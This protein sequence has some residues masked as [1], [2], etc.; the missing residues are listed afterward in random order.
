MFILYAVVIGLIAG[1]AVGGRLD[2][3]G[4]IEFRWPWLAIG[5]FFVQVLL[6]SAAVSSAVGSAGPPV[7]VAS[8]AAVLVAVVRNVH[9]PGLVVVAVGAASNL[10]AIVSNGG[11]MPASPGA[12]ASL[13]RS[14]DDGYTN[15][16]IVAS[17]AFEPLTD[18]YALPGWVPLANVFSVGDV[19]IAAGV[20]MVLVVGMR[21]GRG[22]SPVRDRPDDGVQEEAAPDVVPAP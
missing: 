6:F 4:R 22:S 12:F 8:T 15:S 11:F 19:L 9:I 17:P 21:S 10:L 1:F 20:V 18:V 3:L 13:G 7:Y 14:V 16:A 5:G 2:G